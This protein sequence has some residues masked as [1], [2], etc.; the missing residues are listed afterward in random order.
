M[1]KIV[2]FSVF[3]LFFLN[4]SRDETVDKCNRQRTE[5]TRGRKRSNVQK[6]KAKNSMCWI[7]PAETW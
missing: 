5:R 1:I 2:L 7:S 3:Y 6:K 4:D